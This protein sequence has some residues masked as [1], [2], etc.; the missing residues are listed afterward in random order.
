MIFVGAQSTDGVIIG[1]IGDDVDEALADAARAGLSDDFALQWSAAMGELSDAAAAAAQDQ[2]E[3]VDATG[4]CVAAVNADDSAGS[5]TSGVWDDPDLIAKAA[6]EDGHVALTRPET[7]DPGNAGPE[8]SEA[9]TGEAG[10][11][12]SEEGSSP[13]L[14]CTVCAESVSEA[15]A[16]L[17][18]EQCGEIR[19]KKHTPK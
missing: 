17:S 18:E 11:G 9:E 3:R 13:S 14:D 5:D 7:T 19:C 4:E 8:E 6:A 15:R 12:G 2:R 10:T 16:E 1:G